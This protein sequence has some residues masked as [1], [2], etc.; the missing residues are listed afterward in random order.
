ME[1]T[2]IHL[3]C[4]FITFCT[5]GTCTEYTPTTVNLRFQQDREFGEFWISPENALFP[6]PTFVTHP[7]ETGFDPRTHIYVPGGLSM[8]HMISLSPD[9]ASATLT[10]HL[11]HRPE[12]TDAHAA[13]SEGTCQPAEDGA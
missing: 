9:F 8:P 4:T 3:V 5:G 13:A 1:P 11:P 12:G 7:G 10:T 2:A 6:M